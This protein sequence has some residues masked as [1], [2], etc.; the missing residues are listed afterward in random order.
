M[1]KLVVHYDVTG[2]TDEEIDALE[3][4]A[5][6]IAENK[7]RHPAVEVVEIIQRH[8]D[9]PGLGNTRKPRRKRRR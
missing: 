7:D 8:G 6:A 4:E 3:D 9:D 2:L 1:I 5:R